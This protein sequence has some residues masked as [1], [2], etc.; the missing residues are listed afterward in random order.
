[1]PPAEYQFKL[2]GTWYPLVTPL[3]AQSPLAFLGEVLW[4]YVETDKER[5]QI[6][7][8]LACYV[9]DEVGDH[10]AK[11]IVDIKSSGQMVYGACLFAGVYTI[12]FLKKCPRSN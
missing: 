1:M 8:A 2:N 7:Q 4:N 9:P 3:F 10:L 5:Q 12:L 11:N 6:R